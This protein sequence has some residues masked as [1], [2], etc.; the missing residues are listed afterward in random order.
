MRRGS[1]GVQTIVLLAYSLASF[2]YFE[3]RDAEAQRIF[4]K[5]CR[6]A[7]V[8]LRLG[9]QTIVLLA[10]YLFLERRDAEAQSFLFF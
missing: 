7:G 5:E 4:L 2:C 6:S 3:R 8:T 9:V 10:Y 1:E